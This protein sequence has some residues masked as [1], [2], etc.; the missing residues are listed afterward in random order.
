M[1]DF[2][3]RYGPWAL[4]TGASAGLGATFARALAARGLH[5]ALVARRRERLEELGSELRKQ[6]GVQVLPV[7]LD[8]T[9][10]DA[11]P[12]LQEALGQ[13]PVGLLVNNAGYGAGGGFLAWERAWQTGMV[14]LNCEVPV[15]LAHAFLP[16]MVA[17]G[18]GGLIFLAST[19]A[20][21]ATPYFAV[22]G[23]S[24]AFDLHLGEALRVELRG[25][26]VDVITLSPGPTTS[27]FH[28]IAWGKKTSAGPVMEPGPV[29]ELALRRLGRRDAVVP[30]LA[31][32]IMV[33]GARLAP[34]AWS[35]RV[36]ARLL[37]GR[38]ARDRA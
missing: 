33:W 16:E 28:Q 30:G 6:H 20:Y 18:R 31:N 3:E 35:T 13:R 38:H 19:A 26:G 37:Q 29:V 17:R 2:S 8:L 34:R 22:Y 11:L 32:R 5:L 14:R 27:E 7:A 24:K 15:L 21:M 10:A 23:A 25:S 9:A 4:I 12:R 36:A 1:T